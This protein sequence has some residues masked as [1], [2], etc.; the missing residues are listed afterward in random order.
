MNFFAVCLHYD[1]AM[2]NQIL[3]MRVH[4][5]QATYY[6]TFI[7]KELLIFYV[8]NILSSSSIKIKIILIIRII[9]GIIKSIIKKNV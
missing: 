3:S 4:D 6:E 8:K 1:F 2:T 5:S 7:K 9:K